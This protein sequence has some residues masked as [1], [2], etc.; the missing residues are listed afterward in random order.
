M[1]AS[2][3]GSD[4]PCPLRE[5]GEQITVCVE[6]GNAN[7]AAS[8]TAASP[9]ASPRGLVQAVDSRPSRPFRT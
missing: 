1:I 6:V 5:S 3:F 9:G 2:T 4:V 7:I 8:G